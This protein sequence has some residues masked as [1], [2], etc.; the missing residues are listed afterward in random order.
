VCRRGHVRSDAPRTAFLPDKAYSQIYY[1]Y[2][3]YAKS[4]SPAR[5]FSCGAIVKNGQYTLPPPP[6]LETPR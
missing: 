5:F 1:T 6:L 4:W 3:Q 2:V